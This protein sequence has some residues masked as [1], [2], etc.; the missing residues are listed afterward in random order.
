[1]I[2]ETNNGQ[3]LKD[4]RTFALLA[5]LSQILGKVVISESIILKTKNLR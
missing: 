3:H 1:M 2:K 4:D 5:N